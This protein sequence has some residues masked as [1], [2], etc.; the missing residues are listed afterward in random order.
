MPALP[1]PETR[2]RSKARKDRHEAAV[3]AKVRAAD[4]E[5]DGYCIFLWRIEELGYAGWP[6]GC[7][8]PSELAHLPP[9]TRAHTRG[10][11]PEARHTT[12]HTAMLCRQHHAQ[13]DG[14]Q[15]PRIV[16]RCLTPDGADGPIS[17]EVA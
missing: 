16:V 13:L 12:A 11:P 9:W 4:V 6:L 5:R 2:K 1:K 15:H 7:A 3:I 14:R 8:G 17:V 10:L